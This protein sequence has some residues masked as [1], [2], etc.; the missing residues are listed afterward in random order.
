MLHGEAVAIGM[1][2][3]CRLAELSGA[4]V[5]GITD[6]LCAALDKAQLP[7]VMPPDVDGAT[8]VQLTHADKKARAGAVEYAL[9]QSIG[10]MA[11]AE[12]GWAVALP[13]AFVREALV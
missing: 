9:P 10:A 4:A 1:A 6:E 13:D 5:C 7:T 3:E 2:I 12:T 8:I 11:G